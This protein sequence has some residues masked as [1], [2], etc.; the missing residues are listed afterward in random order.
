MGVK[1]LT[2]WLQISSFSGWV[3]GGS[4]EQLAGGGVSI[5]LGPS[6]SVILVAEQTMMMQEL[7]L[8]HFE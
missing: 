8:L 7:K 3:E 4:L 6:R 1:W 5:S 2:K